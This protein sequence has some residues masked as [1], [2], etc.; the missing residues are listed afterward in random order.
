MSNRN[1]AQYHSSFLYDDVEG[2]SETWSS[3]NTKTITNAQVRSNS[4]IIIM[5]TTIPA[6]RWKIVCSNG[7]F[8]ITSSDAE[9]S[10]TFKYRIL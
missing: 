7:S 4:F 8:V 10:A 2:S 1:H 5:N 6:G 3:G 9:S